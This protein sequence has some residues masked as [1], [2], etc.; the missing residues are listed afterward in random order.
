[1]QAEKRRA[2]RAIRKERRLQREAFAT[3]AAANWPE[4]AWQAFEAIGQ[5]FTQ[6]AKIV[7]DALTEA[8]HPFIKAL[9]AANEEQRRWERMVYRAL[10]AKPSP[11]SAPVNTDG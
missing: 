8:F 5:A 2:L 3:M 11:W 1:M 10:P 6:L 9:L 4:A 7:S